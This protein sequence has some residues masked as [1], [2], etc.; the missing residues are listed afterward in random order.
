[1]GNTTLS[2]LMEVYHE[3]PSLED[4]YTDA[5]IQLWWEGFK[6]NRRPNQ[7]FRKQYTARKTEESAQDDSTSSFNLDDWDV[8]HN[9]LSLSTFSFPEES[10]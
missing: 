6:T 8:W 3:G 9:P 10:D 4:F 5:A 1:M 7:G 2:D